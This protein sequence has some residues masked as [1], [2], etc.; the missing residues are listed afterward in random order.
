MN[1]F[2]CKKH[3]NYKGIRYPSSGCQNCMKIYNSV[4]KETPTCVSLTTPGFHCGLAHF[5]AEASTIML[6]GPQPPLFWRK[7]VEANPEAKKHYKKTWMALSE[8]SKKD[9]SLFSKLETIMWSI[10]GTK[11]KSRIHKQLKKE[12]ERANQEVKEKPEIIVDKE[13]LD[14]LLK[15]FFDAA[16]EEEKGPKFKA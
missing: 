7:N 1:E 4:N 13:Q 5:L 15:E 11:W 9:K 3:P 14:K 2:K 16:K 12:V 8:W 10:F 6:Y